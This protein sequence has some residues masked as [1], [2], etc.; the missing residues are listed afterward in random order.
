[1]RQGPASEKA[2]TEFFQ[3]AQLVL[4]WSGI[5]KRDRLM[6]LADSALETLMQCARKLEPNAA[7][8]EGLSGFDFMGSG[9]SEIY[10]L[11]LDDFP[12]Y[13]SRAGCALAS[14]IILFCEDTGLLGVPDALRL[15]VPKP[16]GLRSA[17]PSRGTYKVGNIEYTQQ[18]L[19]AKSNVKAAWL[20][21]ELASVANAG[22]FIS[23]PAERRVRSMQAGLFTI[24]YEPLR[25]GAVVKS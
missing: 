2:R 9:F 20:P 12:I 6:N 17:N 4:D 10:S 19:Y 24:G 25:P 15:G 14:L 16:D 3:T 13:D 21:K 11:M 5:K 7:T 18:A 23:E 22:Q 8:I 1:M